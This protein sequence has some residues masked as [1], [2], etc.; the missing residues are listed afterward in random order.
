MAIDG[1]NRW[2]IAIGGANRW[3]MTPFQ[4][5]VLATPIV[6]LL[7]PFRAWC[8]WMWELWRGDD[9]QGLVLIVAMRWVW[10]MCGEIFAEGA[11]IELETQS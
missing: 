9:I 1:A 10:Q 2:D 4:G 6:G 8:D 7:R 11:I 3:D 5:L